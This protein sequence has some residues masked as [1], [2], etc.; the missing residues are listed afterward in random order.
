M[1]KRGS[2]LGCKVSI[3]DTDVQG[4]VYKNVD[5][6]KVAYLFGS[7]GGRSMLV[8][9]ELVTDVEGSLDDLKK[10]TW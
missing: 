3:K 9:K 5:V 2:I 10:E 6:D 4:M 7:F 8:R 1:T